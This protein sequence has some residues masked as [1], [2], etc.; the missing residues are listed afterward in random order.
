MTD[1]S[2][3]TIEL[4]SS[5]PASPKY[6]RIK[7]RLLAEVSSGRLTAGDVLPTEI[8]LARNFGVG[9]NTVRQ[10]LAELEQDGLVRRVPGKGTFVQEQNRKGAA[11]VQHALNYFALVVNDAK[12]P[13]HVALLHGFEAAGRDMQLHTLV[14]NTENNVDKQGNVLFNLLGSGILG[15]AMV[16]STDRA[17]PAFQIQKLQEQN[18]PVVFCH[19]GVEGCK[20][21]LI[22]IPFYEIG[23]MAGEAFVKQGHRRIAY[24]CANPAKV[25][26]GYYEGLRK[27]IR[28]GG[29]DLRD[30]DIFIADSYSSDI[31]VLEEK[32]SESLV[33]MFAKADRPTAVF[34][35]GDPIAELI[36]LKMNRLGLSV[37]Q[38]LS[39]ISA[40]GSYRQGAITSRLTSVVTQEGEMGKRAAELLFE[41]HKGRRSIFD[42][43]IINIPLRFIEGRTLGPAP[44]EIRYLDQ[45]ENIIHA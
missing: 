27:A 21:P 43:E 19:R 16:P 41:M 29:G 37:P 35:S 38:D 40:G 9:R 25:Y 8:D 1:R 42:D 11:A 14:N 3:E 6:T 5:R 44:G 13:A 45:K 26:T 30:E 36:Y 15:V 17:T 23:R 32:L 34:A 18:T 24:C 33:R 20:A 7:N 22:P 2:S 31:Y 28:S 10:A 4:R 12:Y 39:L